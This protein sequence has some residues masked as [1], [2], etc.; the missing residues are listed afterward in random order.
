MKTLLD[1]VDSILSDANGDEVDSITDT[2]ESLQCAKL[3]VSV[4]EDI[5]SEYDLQA[6]KKL[7]R[8]DGS[9][10]ILLPTH[11]A[12]P[13]GMHSVEWVKYNKADLSATQADYRDVT[14]ISPEEFINL[15]NRRDDSQ[16]NIQTVTDPSG[17][18]LRI[19]NDKAPEYFTLFNA[20][21]LVFDSFDTG[22]DSFLQQSKTQAYGQ[23]AATLALQDD[24]VVDLPLELT[25]LLVNMS[26]DIYM[27]TH[28][29]GSTASMSKRANRSRVRAQ[30]LRHTMRNN[31]EQFANH[32]GPDYG[33]RPR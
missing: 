7:F 14:Y 9:A 11:M 28:A 21:T 30:R 10:D 22:V 17:V 3:V 18:S 27:D 33:R 1:I 20:R 23:Q 24:A 19:Q 6:G 15:V 5:F 12:I 13:E 4:Y 29:G 2:V 16:T 31:R 25:T 8:L 26:R 32:T